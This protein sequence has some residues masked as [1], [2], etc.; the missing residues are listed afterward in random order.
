M[1]SVPVLNFPQLGLYKPVRHAEI[2]TRICLLKPFKGRT[3]QMRKFRSLQMAAQKLDPFAGQLQRFLNGGV[4]RG[5]SAQRMRKVS[6]A[7]FPALPNLVTLH[8]QRANGK[9]PCQIS[10]T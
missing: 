5:E 1:H 10:H 6:F 8:L 3:L 4:F 7:S 9:F 2:R